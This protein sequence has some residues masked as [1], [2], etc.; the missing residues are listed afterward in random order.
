MSKIYINTVKIGTCPQGKFQIPT[1]R[2]KAAENSVGFVSRG[3][4]PGKQKPAV[5]FLEH[6]REEVRIIL[7]L[8]N[9]SRDWVNALFICT[10]HSFPGRARNSQSEVW[11]IHNCVLL[12]KVAED[13][14]LHPIL[15]RAVRTERGTFFAFSAFSLECTL[16]PGKQFPSANDAKG[17]FSNGLEMKS[18]ESPMPW[19]C[20]GWK[21][22]VVTATLQLS[23]GV[24]QI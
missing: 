17:D 23:G 20:K 22:S 11:E 1:E 7:Q 8:E 14:K 21:R 3:G 18:E 10:Q 24:S 6:W 19:L 4:L 15:S 16:A 9:L 13:T 5:H 12:Q 2:H